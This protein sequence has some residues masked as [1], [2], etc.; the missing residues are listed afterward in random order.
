MFKMISVL[1]GLVLITTGCETST[2]YNVKLVLSHEGNFS[3]NVE[4]C[5]L[6]WSVS[7]STIFRQQSIG[8]RVDNVDLDAEFKEEQ[9]G[10]YV[11]EF[12]NAFVMHSIYYEPPPLSPVVAVRKSQSGKCILIGVQG[13]QGYWYL[14][15]RMPATWTR[16]PQY[17]LLSKRKECKVRLVTETVAPIQ[18]GI[19]KWHVQM[20]VEP[21][22]DL[23]KQLS[24]LNSVP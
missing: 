4:L 3:G 17:R 16:H 20:I 2:G 18:P 22:P 8:Q 10:K 5:S 1:V 14:A 6:H 13:E 23:S 19:A 7:D 21:D 11:F 24:E 9:G 12:R 15:D